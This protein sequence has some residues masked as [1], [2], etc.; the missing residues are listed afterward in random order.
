[1]NDIEQKALALVN[2][3]LRESELPHEPTPITREYW[4]A[5]C[6]AIEQREATEQKLH[7]FRQEVSDELTTYGFINAPIGIGRFII[8]APKTDPLVDAAKM[9]GY[10]NTAANAWAEDVRAALDAVGFEIREKNDDQ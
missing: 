10:F 8:P 5:L 3:V 6:R 7:D 9:M 1:M 4:K 2:E